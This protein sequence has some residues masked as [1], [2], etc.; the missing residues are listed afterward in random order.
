MQTV[1]IERLMYVARGIEFRL[2][3]IPKVFTI[4]GVSISTCGATA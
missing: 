3:P 2:Q 1:N 4:R